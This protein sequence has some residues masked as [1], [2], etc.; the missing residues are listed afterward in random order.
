M[1]P[2]SMLKALECCLTKK[3]AYKHYIVN[4]ITISCGHSACKSCISKLCQPIK[5]SKC[6]KLNETDVSKFG[7]SV[8]AKCVLKSYISDLFKISCEEMKNIFDNLKSNLKD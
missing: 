4:P 6:G 5:C 2:N 8:L 1:L 7:E 3:Q